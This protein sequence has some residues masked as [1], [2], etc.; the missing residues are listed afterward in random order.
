MA[1]WVRLADDG[2]C[3]VPTRAMTVLSQEGSRL[4]PIYFG[5]RMFTENGVAVPR[6]S[7]SGTSVDADTGVAWSHAESL[8][9]VD[10]SS[11]GSWT[12]LAS[13]YDEPAHEL[14]LYINGQLIDRAPY[15][16]WNAGGGFRIGRG[17]YK[18]NPVDYWPGEI[19]EVQVFTGT[20]TDGQV[21]NLAMDQP[22]DG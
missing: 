15:T 11:I 10:C 9:P 16:G 6:W 21:I 7:V 5:I 12:H 19:D 20:L 17:K 13:V 14:K 4:N 8:D 1:A 3:S 18:G 22:V 2:Q